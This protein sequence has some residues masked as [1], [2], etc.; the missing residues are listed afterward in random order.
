MKNRV[1]VSRLHSWGVPVT[2][3]QRKALPWHQKVSWAWRGVHQ[4]WEEAN[5]S[6]H[7][8]AALNL[9]WKPSSKRRVKEEEASKADEKFE[10]VKPCSAVSSSEDSKRSEKSH[11]GQP[12][13]GQEGTRN[14]LQP[15][16]RSIRPKGNSSS[17]PLIAPCDSL[18]L[19][20]F[21]RICPTIW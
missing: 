15:V 16:F 9:P 20:G 19:R 10:L 17:Q 6:F 8:L 5:V 4:Q 7:Q 2:L 1:E 13:P 3:L 21:E 14:T 12:G 18:R 11:F